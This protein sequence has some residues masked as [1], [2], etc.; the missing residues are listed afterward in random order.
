M[1]HI[2]SA[3]LFHLTQI[4]PVTWDNDRLTP[5][6]PFPHTSIWIEEWIS[7]RGGRCSRPVRTWT[8]PV[9]EGSV[10][11][12]LQRGQDEYHWRWARWANGDLVEMTEVEAQDHLDPAGATA[13][14]ERRQAAR[15]AKHYAVSRARGVG[16]EV[17]VYKVNKSDNHIMVVR[18][19][20]REYYW[21]HAR[22]EEIAEYKAD[23]SAPV[24]ACQL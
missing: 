19:T 9:V 6:K 12:R 17:G 2:Q 1:T 23:A 21:R 16:M 13:R 15:E 10:I 7:E 4:H 24:V 3:P 14:A 5:G 20:A 8:L 18:A 11:V 22:P